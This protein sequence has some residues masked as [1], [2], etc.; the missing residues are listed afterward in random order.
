MVPGESDEVGIP[1]ISAL[2]CPPASLDQSLEGTRHL[3]WWSEEGL[4]GAGSGKRQ[5]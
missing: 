3:R 1:G 4:V 2:F 5:T